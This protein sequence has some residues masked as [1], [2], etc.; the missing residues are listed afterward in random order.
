MI[1]GSANPLLLGQDGAGGYAIERSLRFNSGD[2]S[3]LNRTPS[4]AGNTKTFTWAGWVKRSKLGI[5]Q[6]IISAGNYGAVARARIHFS[7][8]D[9]L[10]FGNYSREPNTL[11]I[12]VDVD[13]DCEQDTLPIMIGYDVG[14]IKIE[15]NQTVWNG[16][17]WVDTFFNV[18]GWEGDELELISGPEYFTEP[19]TGWYIIWVNL[20]A[21]W[22]RDG[23]YEYVTSF[24]IE[25]LYLEEEE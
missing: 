9:N 12:T 24:N 2:S 10:E 13:T 22:N 23:D 18:T 3:Y 17:M 8:G 21:D 7:S 15:D 25:K 16:Y 5:S 11:N 14:H 19:Y 6:N 1:P 20:F 4:V